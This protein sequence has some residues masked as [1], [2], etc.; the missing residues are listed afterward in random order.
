MEFQGE[1]PIPKIVLTG[2]PC[3]G[4]TTS[5]AQLVEALSERGFMTFVIPETATFVTNCGIDRRRMWNRSQILRYEEAILDLQI[6]LEEKMEKWARSVFGKTNSVIILDRGI[7]DIK[8]FLPEGFSERFGRML[9]SRGLD[10]DLVKERYQAIIHLNTCA[11]G[12]ENFYNLESNR[13]RMESVEEAREIDSKIKLAWLGHPNFSV[14]GNEEDFSEKVRKVI[15]KVYNFLGIREPSIKGRRFLVES[16]DEKRLKKFE[17]TEITE[18]FLRPRKKEILRLR[19]R[20]SR[21]GSLY[22]LCR[23]FNL[24]SF[25]TEVEQL[26]D[27][28]TFFE[29]LRMKDEKKLPILKKRFC[30]LWRDSYFKLDVYQK[31]VEDLKI[32]IT[33]SEEKDHILDLPPFIR[34]RE[35]IT[36]SSIYEEENLALKKPRL[37]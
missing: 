25:A 34:I 21:G 8:A 5:I 32:L 7:M 19:R 18:F 33:E 35:E 10:E 28:S 37:L 13:A 6:F 29:M 1:R 3:S 20:F 14:V 15:A 4:K 27:E 24:D 23:R 36:E 12:F 22:I 16:I 2:G 30:F 11:F 31:P 9:K 26:I 17:V